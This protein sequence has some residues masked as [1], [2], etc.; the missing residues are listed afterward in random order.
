MKGAWEALAAHLR[1]KREPLLA[2]AHRQFAKYDLM[3]FIERVQKLISHADR[4]ADPS[5]KLRAAVA[6]SLAEWDKS[7]AFAEESR[8]VEQHHALRIATKHLRYRAEL[9]CDSG[10]ISVEPMVKDLKEIQS[11]LGDWHDNCVLLQCVDEFVARPEFLVNRPQMTGAL[12]AQME[13]E[14]TRNVQAIENILSRA[15]KLRK[16]W[17]DWQAQDERRAVKG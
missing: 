14:K 4:A 5:A 2:D 7:Y 1:N 6:R 15:I 17:N 11:T 8:S 12:R 10:T 9:L 16:R 3:I 13:Q